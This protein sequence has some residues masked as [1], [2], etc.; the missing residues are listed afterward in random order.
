MIVISI[1]MAN[2]GEQVTVKRI[3]GKDETR[4]HL[5]ELGL[6]EGEVITVLQNNGGNLILQV[7]GGRVALDRALAMRIQM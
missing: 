5:H 7:K 1:I 4:H 2:V 3:T 6:R